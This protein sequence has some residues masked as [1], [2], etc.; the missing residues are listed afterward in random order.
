MR[1]EGR[2]H[3]MVRTY[4]VL[5]SPLNPRPNS[6]ILN[7]IDYPPTAGIFAKIS[8]KPTNHS[9]FTGKCEKVR[10]SGCHFHPISKSRDKSKGTQKLKSSD[11]AFNYQQ[12]TWRVVGLHKLQKSGY[13]ASGILNE[14]NN[15]DYDDDDDDDD[16]KHEDE[17]GGDSY[18]DDEVKTEIIVA[19]TSHHD[20]IVNVDVDEII[21]H[22]GVTDDNDDG[23]K[24]FYDVAYLMNPMDEDEEGWSVIG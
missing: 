19:A 21:V 6:R 18:V 8:N 12:D 11:S 15:L 1:R 5:P 10:C 9:K 22:V 4:H 2:P 17:N 13:S 24:G 7:K 14:L 3:G 23:Y 20:D 16:D